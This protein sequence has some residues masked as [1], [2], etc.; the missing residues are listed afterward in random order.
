MNIAV[1][2]FV[3]VACSIGIF[4]VASIIGIVRSY[5]FK[6]TKLNDLIKKVSAKL[7]KLLYVTGE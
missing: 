2:P 7:D 4:T 1:M 5:I 6:I 3:I